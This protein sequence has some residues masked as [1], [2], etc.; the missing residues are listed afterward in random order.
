MIDSQQLDDLAKRLAGL[1]PESMSRFQQ[2]IEKNLKAGLKGVLQ[3][4]DL[5]TREEYDVQAALLARAQKRLAEL[6]QRIQAME[7]K[8]DSDH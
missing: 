1:M 8:A 5:V 4:M 2:D 7:E 6:E 3:K